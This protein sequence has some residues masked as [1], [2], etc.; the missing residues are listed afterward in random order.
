[1]Q[2]SCIIIYMKQV[3]SPSFHWVLPFLLFSFGYFGTWYLFRKK[4]IPM[5]CIVGMSVHQAIAITSQ[6][7]LNIRLLGYKHE[8]DLQPG[9]ILSQIPLSGTLVKPQQ[10]VFVVISQEPALPSMPQATQMHSK[11]IVSICEKQNIIPTLYYIPHTWPRDM[12][13]AQSPTAHSPIAKNNSPILYIS[14]SKP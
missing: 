13:F 14:A 6:H 11:H 9:I 8:P 5:P 2:V 12:C 3:I 7:T 4:A 1:M 10:S